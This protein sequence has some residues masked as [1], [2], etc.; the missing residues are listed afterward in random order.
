[1]NKF[2]PLL[3]LVAGLILIVSGM[4]AADS[5]GSDLS[6]LFN[7]SPTD[8]SIWLLIGGIAA[9]VAGAVGLIRPT[10]AI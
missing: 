7:G 8:K 9:F 3:F 1:M 10:K 4:I 5:L 2:V 6:H